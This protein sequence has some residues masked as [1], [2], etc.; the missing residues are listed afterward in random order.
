MA[1]V[2]ITSILAE[3]AIP[4]FEAYLQRA[5][6]TEGP[7]A[8]QEMKLKAEAYRAEFL[9]YPVYNGVHDPGDIKNTGN[10]V[11]D[12]SRLVSNRQ[13]RFPATD[14]WFNE[15]GWRPEGNMVRFGY[16]WAAGTPADADTVA[17]LT[18]TYGLTL[19]IDHY[20][21]AQATAD[22]NA[23]GRFVIFEVTSFTRNV[24]CNT[25]RGWD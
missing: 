19:P 16:G 1:V 3:T 21:I 14:Q 11:P 5:R 17:S 18:T 10:H 15:L 24:W 22:F 13:E 9:Q 12:K 25:G 7:L 2:T 4:S 23:D 6:S 20:F 8:L